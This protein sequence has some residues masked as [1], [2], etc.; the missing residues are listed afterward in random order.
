MKSNKQKWKKSQQNMSYVKD[1]Y[2]GSCTQDSKVM[3][4]YIACKPANLTD[5]YNDEMEATTTKLEE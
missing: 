1:K 5:N 3:K 2:S 4:K